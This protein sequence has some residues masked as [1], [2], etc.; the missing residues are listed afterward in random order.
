MP[1]KKL[2]V[3]LNLQIHLLGRQMPKKKRNLTPIED[4][5]SQSRMRMVENEKNNTPRQFRD[6]LTRA[7]GAVRGVQTNTTNW[8]RWS[9]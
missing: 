7:N 6:K 5:A 1:K 4:L 2:P 3:H 8:G 9:P